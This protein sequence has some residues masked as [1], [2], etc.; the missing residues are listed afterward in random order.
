MTL[1]PPSIVSS[2]SNLRARGVPELRPSRLQRVEPAVNAAIGPDRPRPV[3]LGVGRAPRHRGLNV[4]PA[5]RGVDDGHVLSVDMPPQYAP[6]DGRLPNYYRRV[7]TRLYATPG[8]HSARTGRLLLEHKGIDYKRVDLIPAVHKPLLRA[9][10]FPRNTVPAL[11]IDG[12][13]IQGTRNISRT[14][15]EL[16]PE[17][18]LF[19][20]DPGRRAAVEEAE[21]WGDEVLQPVPRRLA[22]WALKRDRSQ[23]RSFLEGSRL[24]VP[25]GLAARTA[26]PLIWISARLN[27]ADDE[28]VRDDLEALPAMLNQVDGWIAEGILSTDEPNAADFQIA[29]SVRLLMCFDDLGSEIQARPAGGLA[30]RICPEF[31]G[32]IGPVLGAIRPQRS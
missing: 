5:E 30:M 1:G 22:W 20:A 19:P 12:Q 9:L 25:L 21:R 10:G 11:R 15:D 29:T 23:V 28:A 4:T 17:S 6:T 26:A 32:R 14:L 27:R 3:V 7:G 16:R 8:S 24:G 31:P 2:T 13:R 18:P